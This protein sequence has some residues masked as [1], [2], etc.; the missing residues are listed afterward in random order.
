MCVEVL[1]NL[2][3]H[4]SQ[5]QVAQQLSSLEAIRSA[6]TAPPCSARLTTLHCSILKFIFCELMLTASGLHSKQLRNDVL[7]LCLRIA[8]HCPD[9]PFV[10]GTGFVLCIHVT[11]CVCRRLGL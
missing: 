3:E 10:V 8:Q 2:L 9:A 6:A 5:I 4:G 1:W 11:L 7:M